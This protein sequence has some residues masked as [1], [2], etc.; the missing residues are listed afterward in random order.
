MKSLLDR[1]DRVHFVGIAGSGMSALARL[2]LS[3][4]LQVSGSD[5]SL[6]TQGEALQRLG[7][8]VFTG[9][10]A[11]FVDGAQL[12]VIT[13]AVADDNPEVLAAATRGIPVIKRAELLASIVN[14]AYGIAVAG[15]HGKT[16]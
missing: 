5:R 14:P 6:G 12:L 3:R 1:C 9:H 11:T 2:L 15:T 8:R 7:A 16:T 4:G 10:D 13:S